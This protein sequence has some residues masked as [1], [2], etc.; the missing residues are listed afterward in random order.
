V[1]VIIISVLTEPPSVG[2]SDVVVADG[3]SSDIELEVVQSE[4]DRL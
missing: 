3:G 1:I 2:D 4:T